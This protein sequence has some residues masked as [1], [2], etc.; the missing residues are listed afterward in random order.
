MKMQ[1]NGGITLIAL[2]ITII[3]LLILAAVSLSLIAGEQGIL[4][5]AESAVS[6]NEIAGAK[7]EVDLLVLDLVSQYYA[8]KYDGNIVGEVDDYIVNHEEAQK[9]LTSGYKVNITKKEV[10]L[11]KEENR[12]ATGV[13]ENGKIIWDAVPKEKVPE[14]YA[15]LYT[16][17]TLIFS[18]FDYTDPTRT[19]EEDYGEQADWYEYDNNM[20]VD[21]PKWIDCELITAEMIPRAV[22]KANNIIIY[23]EIAPNNMYAWFIG[24]VLESVQLEKLN[25]KNVKSMESLFYESSDL[26]KLNLSHFDTSNVTNMEAMFAYCSSLT[27]LEASNF[28]TS[29]VTDMSRMFQYCSSLTEL[30]L[31]N[32]DTSNVT[33]MNSMFYSCRNLTQL[34]ISNFEI[35]DDTNVSS[36]FSFCNSELTVYV[37]DEATKNKIESENGNVTI[38]VKNS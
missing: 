36:M 22:N 18:S 10:E 32:F 20:G 31:S 28:D 1:K 2:V 4:Q 6:K 17:K 38:L 34:D 8:E 7:E 30:D 25:T 26:K 33:D 12:V 11:K 35:K 19:V 23:D 27:E 15:K 3:V 24:R 21:V 37:K 5:R 13:L 16:D 9:E 29:N 14:I